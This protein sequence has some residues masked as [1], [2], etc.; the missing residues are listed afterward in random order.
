MV[1]AMRL[2]VLMGVSGS[3]KTTV[4]QCLAARNNAA[5]FD[6]DDFHPPANVEKMA[7]GMPL[8]DH[9]RAPWLARLRR[10]VIDAVPPG[11]LA[12]LACSALKRA[13]R[14]QLGVGANGVALVYLQA[15]PRVLERRIESRAGHFMKAGMLASQLA[16]LEPPDA[17]EGVTVEARE[18]E[19]ATA[20]AIESA[21]R[22]RSGPMRPD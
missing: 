16:A 1:T 14:L 7:A 15:D 2:L 9:D 20:I 6:A 8:D 4:G 18:G 21:L 22:L 17:D 12:V 13:Y 19:E 3:G 11:G 10:E 5:F